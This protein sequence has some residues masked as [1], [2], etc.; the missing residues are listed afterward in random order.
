MLFFATE[1]RIL[2]S[3]Q[4]LQNQKKKSEEEKHQKSQVER[5]YKTAIETCEESQ[6]KLAKLQQDI[7][8]KENAIQSLQGQLNQAKQSLD[9]ETTKVSICS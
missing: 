7:Q 4:A 2:Y 6:R 3:I 1:F 9:N 8:V 5:D